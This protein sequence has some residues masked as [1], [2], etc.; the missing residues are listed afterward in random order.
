M[1]AHARPEPLMPPR[2]SPAAKSAQP[3]RPCALIPP[4]ASQLRA[5]AHCPGCDTRWT[6]SCTGVSNA[7]MRALP[8]L[9]HKMDYQLYR[10]F[11]CAHARTAR[12]CNARWTGS[13][14][15]VSIAHM[16]ALPGLRR[17]MDWLLYR[18][19]NC[20]HCPLWVC[21]ARSS[22]AHIVY[23]L[24]HQ[25]CQH[26]QHHAAHQPRAALERHA[27]AQISAQH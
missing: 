15:G 12:V 6:G 3:A 7:H 22:D 13:C 24:Y 20:A 16:R 2:R 1:P 14:T 18:R 11:N 21:V 9:L 10:R 8:E 27:A 23:Q 5:C 17:N 4:S 25:Q 19:F 26:H